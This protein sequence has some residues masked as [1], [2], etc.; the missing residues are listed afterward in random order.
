MGDFYKQDN[1][2]T[3]L[4]VMSGDFALESVYYIGSIPD[5]PQPNIV[6]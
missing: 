2:F 3:Y 6:V 5:D 1:K 4:N